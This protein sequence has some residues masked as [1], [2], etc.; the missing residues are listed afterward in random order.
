MF[1]C[2]TARLE[3]DPSPSKLCAAMERT[4]P[5]VAVLYMHIDCD[6]LSCLIV[7]PL[8]SRNFG[9]YFLWTEV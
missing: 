3:K 5:S 6:L 4:S 7:G 9:T 1:S 8:A 2:I